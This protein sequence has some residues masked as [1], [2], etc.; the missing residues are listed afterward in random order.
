M[1]TLT[2]RALPQ[3]LDA[4]LER[5]LIEQVGTG[6]GTGCPAMLR[7]ARA[8]LAEAR[9]GGSSSDLSRLNRLKAWLAFCRY[10][11]TLYH[12]WS[13]ACRGSTRAATR[14]LWVMLVRQYRQEVE[15]GPRQIEVCGRHLAELDRRI[16]HG[17]AV[18]RK[19]KRK[20]EWERRAL[21][22][23]MGRFLR[24]RAT[25]LPTYRE[26]RGLEPLVPKL[27]GPEA[28]DWFR[29]ELEGLGS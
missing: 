13:R 5:A 23:A 21:E 12:A 28:E 9:Q 11:A 25:E 20:L 1:A 24:L 17:L 14:A 4:L 27:S 16:A 2:L 18:G 26:W 7:E 10:E 22:E 8:T 3:P 15:A 6:T 29:R 19:I